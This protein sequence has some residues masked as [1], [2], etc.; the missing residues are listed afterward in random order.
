MQVVN[1]FRTKICTSVLKSA[2]WY[3]GQV[4][5]G[6]CEIRVLTSYFYPCPKGDIMITL[7]CFFWYNILIFQ[8]SAAWRSLSQD[9][10]YPLQKGV[11]ATVQLGRHLT[12]LDEHL[13]RTLQ[14]RIQ[15]PSRAGHGSFVAA[16]GSDVWTQHHCPR[17]E[18]Y[19]AIKHFICDFTEQ[20][21]GT[22]EHIYSSSAGLHS[23][24]ND[25]KNYAIVSIDEG[26]LILAN[27]SQLQGGQK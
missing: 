13:L 7:C 17:C 25:N 10:A 8:A 1:S 3:M 18:L 27:T 2:L 15:L 16:Y 23:H 11:W 4:N 22:A 12:S 14:G 20:V 24:H 19:A 5:F 21:P 9:H 6:I 26:H